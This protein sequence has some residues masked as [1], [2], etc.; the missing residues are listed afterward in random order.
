MMH[1]DWTGQIVVE[2]D[3]TTEAAKALV[4]RVTPVSRSIV[5][6][7]K[8]PPIRIN[9]RPYRVLRHLS[10]PGLIFIRPVDDTQTVRQARR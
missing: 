3:G 9:N 7:Q 2:T 10:K 1:P 6:N 5:A 4:K 8:P